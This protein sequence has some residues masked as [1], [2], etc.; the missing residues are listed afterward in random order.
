MKVHRPGYVLHQVII[1]PIGAPT[2]HVAGAALEPDSK[3]AVRR[4]PPGQAGRHE[5][6]EHHL[7]SL[8]GGDRLLG[9]IYGDPLFHRGDAIRSRCRRHRS[10]V[11]AVHVLLGARTSVTNLVPHLVPDRDP[12]QDVDD[13][14]AR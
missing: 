11:L 10:D 13:R 4:L 12:I 3:E 1:V 5:R 9:T 6:S 8:I 2:R 14:V 7:V